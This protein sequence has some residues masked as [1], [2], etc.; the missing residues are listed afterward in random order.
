MVW[1]SSL[2]AADSK[3]PRCRARHHFCWMSRAR[4]PLDEGER[5]ETELERETGD[6]F[7][8]CL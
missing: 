1:K 2:K 4:L 5:S 8:F 6:G 7:Y 3:G